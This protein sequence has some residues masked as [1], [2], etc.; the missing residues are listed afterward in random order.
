MSEI[1]QNWAVVIHAKVLMAKDIN[2]NQKILVGLIS[3]LTNIDDECYATNEYFSSILG[4]NKSSNYVSKLICDLEKKGYLKTEFIYKKNSKEIEKRIIRIT[5]QFNKGGIVQKYKGGVVQNYQG[6]VVQKYQE[7]NTL[8]NSNTLRNTNTLLNQK[9]N[10]THFVQKFNFDDLLAFGKAEIEK[11]NLDFSKYEYS[12]K[13]KLE[14]WQESDWK[15]GHGKPIKNPK[16][17]IKNI[18]PYLK[19]M[20]IPKPQQKNYENDLQKARLNFKP[21]SEY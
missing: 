1:Q 6:G 11:L 19:P 3:N 4:M 15:D 20:E 17:K 5:M 9:T 18:I 16:L 10:N 12:L 2:P 21:V 8:L 7:N 13:T 14:T